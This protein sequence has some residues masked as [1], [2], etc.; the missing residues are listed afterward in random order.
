MAAL[1][2]SERSAGVDSSSRWFVFH[3]GRVGSI[4]SWISPFERPSFYSIWASAVLQ[5]T[6]AGYYQ[7]TVEW[8]GF[9]SA[10]YCK[11]VFA[12]SRTLKAFDR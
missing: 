3:L 9:S 7:Q 2:L 1:S 11:A 12:R 5:G 4:T 6:T 8:L 10:R